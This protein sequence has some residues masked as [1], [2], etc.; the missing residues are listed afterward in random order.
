MRPGHFDAILQ[1]DDG[2]Q[3]VF[4]A[5]VDEDPNRH[6]HEARPAGD[7]EGAGRCG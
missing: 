2:A 6:H 4:V 7:D 5:G 3:V 1:P